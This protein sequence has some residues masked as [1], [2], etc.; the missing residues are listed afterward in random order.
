MYFFFTDTAITRI[1]T[2]LHTLSLHDA[3]PIFCVWA[4]WGPAPALAYALVNA[5]AVLI[6]A[7]P[8]ALGLATTM[9]IMTGTG[10]GAQHGSLIRNAEA[11]ETL[12]KIDTLVVDKTGTLTMGKPDLVAVTPRGGI[13]EADFLGKVAAVETGSEHPL[14]HAI[15]EGAKSR[16]V[17]FEAA[18][19]LS[20]TTGE[21]VEARVGPQQVATERKSTRRS[22]RKSVG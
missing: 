7:C 17:A 10:K 6:I 4:V 22:E 18:S 21:G 19:D 1:Y 13:D 2:N 11:L 20:S 8:C 15:V 9:S 14:A 12:E 16:G 3:L 5:I